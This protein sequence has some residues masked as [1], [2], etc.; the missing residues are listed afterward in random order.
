MTG[1]DIMAEEMYSM[2]DLSTTSGQNNG[3]LCPIVFTELQNG[4]FSLYTD[5][6]VRPESKAGSERKEKVWRDKMAAKASPVLITHVWV[7]FFKE[8]VKNQ[9][10]DCIKVR[11]IDIV[12]ARRF[13]N[14]LQLKFMEI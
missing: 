2:S 10:H 12:S 9:H 7:C 13:L 5:K 4:P 6:S 11:V 14:I 8:L 3:P 1:W